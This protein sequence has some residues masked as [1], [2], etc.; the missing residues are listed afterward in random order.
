M[1][2]DG[3][4]CADS[5][6]KTEET[7]GS[8]GD[9]PAPVGDPPTG[10]QAATARS[11]LSESVEGRSAA[12]SGESPD[13]TGQWPVIPSKKIRAFMKVCARNS[14]YV[15]VSD[16]TLRSYLINPVA[17]LCERRKPVE[18]PCQ[19]AVTDRRYKPSPRFMR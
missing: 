3:H 11:R 16:E 13:G 8:A 18:R 7:E 19:T 4:R 15:R 9:S 5:Q 17:A 2:T 14:R 1:T 6:E 12:P 10:T